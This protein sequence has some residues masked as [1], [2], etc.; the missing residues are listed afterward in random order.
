M[1][2]LGLWLVLSG[3]I[4]LAAYITPGVRIRGIT[5]SLIV[6]FLLAVLNLILK[7]ILIILTLPINILTLGLFTFI[8][9]AFII[10]I[11]DK[12]VEKFKVDGFFWAILYGIVLTIVTSILRHVF[13]V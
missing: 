9:N 8:I 5:T 7:P 2:I 13:E 12:M 3:A 10:V 4:L 6:S 11:I 1:S